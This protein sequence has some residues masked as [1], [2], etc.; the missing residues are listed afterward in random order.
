MSSATI[1]SFIFNSPCTISISGSTSSGKTSF[2][3]EVI[4]NK[5]EIFETPPSKI[6]YCYGTWQ[7]L[8]EKIEDVD[9]R[10]GL[11]LDI[12]SIQDSAPFQHTLIVLDD[13]MDEVTKN[14]EIQHLFTRG[15]HHKNITVMYINQNMFFQGKCSRTINLN[16][17]Y[18]ILFRNPRDIQQISTLGSQLGMRE[19]LSNA[20]KDA[21]NQPYGYLLVDLSPHNHTEFKL[22]SHILPSQD[23]VVYL[24]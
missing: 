13:L 9:F 15:S 24:K 3:L 19:I 2:V 14:D 11:M 18:L 1:Q 6:I 4:K 21:T 20:Y 23:L 5:N 17:M 10:K 12:D 8:F 7:P 16:S 22:K